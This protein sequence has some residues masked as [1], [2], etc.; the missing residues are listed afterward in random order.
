MTSRVLLVGEMNPY[1][2]DPEYAL[3]HL[4]TGASGDRLRRILG[5]DSVA[6]LALGR[7]NLCEGRWSMPAA[8][9]R[10][11]ALIRDASWTSYVLL[12]RKVAGAFGYTEPAF[13]AQQLTWHQLD[14][15][16]R[17]H[18]PV[19]V[20]SLPH[21]SGLNRAWN[22]AGSVDKA[23]DLLCLVVPAVQWGTA[24]ERMSDLCATEPRPVR[25]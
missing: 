2:E 21:P 23:R 22:V 8:R 11:A 1:G 4:P 24:D 15:L 18:A 14:G 17:E 6:Y 25:A 10:A 9:A 20:V 7:V 16:G 13:S 5:L 19:V 12:G 3:Y